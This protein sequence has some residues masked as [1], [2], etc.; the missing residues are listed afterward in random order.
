MVVKLLIEHHLEFLSLKGGC[1][2]S[3][4]STHVNMPHCSKS[5]AL[6]QIIIKL[7]HCVLQVEL[8][9][10]STYTI[11]SAGCTDTCNEMVVEQNGEKTTTSCCSTSKC[12]NATPDLFSETS[13]VTM[14]DTFLCICIS[15][16]TVLLRVLSLV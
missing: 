3:S 14:S 16:N 4:E 8:F 6:A 12:N 1:R 13:R 11:T 2:G 15:L 7:H 9:E 10:N 5:H